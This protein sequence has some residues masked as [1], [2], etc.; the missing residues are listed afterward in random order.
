MKI[1][2]LG[3][4][5]DPVHLGHLQMAHQAKKLLGVAQVW[6]L[7][8]KKTPLKDRQLTN[9]QDRLAML[10]MALAPYPGY[11]VCTLE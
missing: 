6:F 5:F 11:I 8:T 3:G 1:A 2:I 10:E 7:P 4:S 9:D